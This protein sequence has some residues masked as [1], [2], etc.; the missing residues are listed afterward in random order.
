M[1]MVSSFFVPLIWLINPLQISRTFKRKKQFGSQV[2]TQ[3]EVNQLMM[4]EP[5]SLGKLFS[6][7]I[8]TIWFTYMYSSIIPA[9][10]ILVLVGLAINYWVVKFNILRRSSIDH[11]V[12]GKFI[13]MALSLLDFSLIMKPVG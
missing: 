2:L 13:M 12:S 5:A 9:G 6:E 10:G 8:E 4:D 7:T 11:Q 3:R 1:F